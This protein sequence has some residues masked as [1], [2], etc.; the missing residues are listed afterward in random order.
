VF[1]VLNAW[2]DEVKI[3]AFGEELMDLRHEVHHDISQKR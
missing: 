3:A 1:G 2:L